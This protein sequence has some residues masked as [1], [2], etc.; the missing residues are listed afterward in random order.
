MVKHFFSGVGTAV[1]SSR[2][3]ILSKVFSK[4]NDQTSNIEI[5]LK[6]TKSYF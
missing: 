2:F 4:N 6:W 3:F 1:R 5:T